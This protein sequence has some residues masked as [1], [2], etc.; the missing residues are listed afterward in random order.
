MFEDPEVPVVDNDTDVDDVEYEDD[1][2]SWSFRWSIMTPMLMMQ[3]M[4]MMEDPE[5][6]WLIITPMSMRQR[7]KM[8]EDPEFPVVDNDIDM[9]EM[10]D[11][12]G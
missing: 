1:G 5:V 7:K 6:R 12:D 9:D 11:D 2:G 3:K 4:K 8:I 10:E